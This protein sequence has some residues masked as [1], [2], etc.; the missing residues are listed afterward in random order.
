MDLMAANEMRPPGMLRLGMMPAVPS[1]S[2]SE[3]MMKSTPSMVP[4]CWLCEGRALSV[5]CV[6]VLLRCC[7]VLWALRVRT[8]ATGRGSLSAVARAA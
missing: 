5:G 4:V 7:V 6:R 8:T 3:M 1:D 2:L